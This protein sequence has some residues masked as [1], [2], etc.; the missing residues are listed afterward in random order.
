MFTLPGVCRTE[1]NAKKW[2]D[3]GL[4]YHFNN[5]GSLGLRRDDI[6]QESD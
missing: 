4:I 1:P 3:L 6:L 2:L 5:G